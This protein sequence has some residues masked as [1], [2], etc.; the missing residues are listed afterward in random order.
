MC[1]CTDAS[2]PHINICMPCTSRTPDILRTS[3]GRVASFPWLQDSQPINP[4]LR[5]CSGHVTPAEQR[6]QLTFEQKG[7]CC[8]CCC[9]WSL[10]L[11]KTGR[12]TK[13]EGIFGTR[14][15]GCRPRLLSCCW[16]GEGGVQPSL[17]KQIQETRPAPTNPPQMFNYK[18]KHG[19]N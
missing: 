18:N 6:F 13:H 9:C 19:F 5:S 12:T 14:L 17:I 7:L 3:A 11:S 4:T 16:G 2:A 8:C 1:V 10:L 15:A